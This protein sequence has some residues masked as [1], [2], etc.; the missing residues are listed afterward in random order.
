VEN[1]LGVV[2]L[3]VDKLDQRLYLVEEA[4]N[5]IKFKFVTTPSNR[6][7]KIEDD[8]RLVKSKLGIS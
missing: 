3:K 2:E 1:R 8:M 5:H 7:D 4:T 6:L